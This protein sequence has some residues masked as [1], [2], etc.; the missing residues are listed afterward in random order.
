MSDTSK[1]VAHTLNN[2]LGMIAGYGE[3]VRRQLGP[4]HAQARHLEHIL[5]SASRAAELVRVLAVQAATA[6]PAPAPSKP[7]AGLGTILLVEDDVAL[8]ELVA[9]ALEGA[10]YG[11]VAAGN[12]AEAIDSVHR[13]VGPIDLILSDV[14]L[15]GLGGPELVRQL[16]R[17]RPGMKVLYMTGYTQD[18][19]FG[20]GLLAPGSPLLEKPFNA[21]ILL[22]RVHLAMVETATAGAPVG[23]VAVS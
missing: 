5:E 2:L 15:P 17:L 16:Q 19:I 22:D 9:E 7:A 13:H 4:D 1:S 8:R 20:R 14:V 23:V 10:G 6:A 3:L 12:G 11:V 18:V 21:E